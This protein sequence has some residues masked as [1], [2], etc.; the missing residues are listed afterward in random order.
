M[1]DG[2]RDLYTLLQSH[3]RAAMGP[4]QPGDRTD[5]GRVAATDGDYIKIVS[6]PGLI[7]LH[8]KSGSAEFLLTPPVLDADNPQRGLMGMIN[9]R[10]KTLS[11]QDDFWTFATDTGL[12]VCSGVTPAEAVLMA[13]AYQT[14]VRP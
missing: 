2:E 6:R 8:H 4:I 3:L 10:R 7:Y 9:G 12:R 5:R 1:T 13:L 14:G 11:C